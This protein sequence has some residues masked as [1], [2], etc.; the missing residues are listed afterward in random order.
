MGSG[1]CL[2]V[3]ALG[4]LAG[5]GETIE[6]TRRVVEVR[7]WLASHQASRRRSASDWY[8]AVFAYVLVGAMLAAAVSDMTV[9]L[10]A[11]PAGADSVMSV[12][13]ALVLASS[14][15][16]AWLLGPLTVPAP[17][18]WWLYSSPL[19]R[20][21]LLH[22]P[23]LKVVAAAVLAGL[24]VVGLVWL[25][26]APTAGWVTAAATAPL[27]GTMLA[28]VV[29][30]HRGSPRVWRAAP[31]FLIAVVVC[32]LGWVVAAV[33]AVS[34]MVLGVSAWR[35]LG[36]M[37]RFALEAAGRSA[38]SI[39]GGAI[40]V[41]STLLLDLVQGRLSRPARHRLRGAGRGWR[42]LAWVD[43]QRVASR[44]TW[45]MLGGA[46]AADAA[47]VAIAQVAPAL[48]VWAALVLMPILAAGMGT[49]R[50]LA[51]SVGLRRT[52]PAG[53]LFSLVSATGAVAVAAVNAVA[54][55]VMLT[56]PGAVMLWAVVTALVLNCAA[57]LGAW[58]M[59]TTASSDFSTGL[60]V[61]EA[62]V[63]PAGAML[64]MMRG[65][66]LLVTVLFVW[67]LLT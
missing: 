66:D 57:L 26:W 39:R 35:G 18:L 8:V 21:E 37:S 6:A 5:M 64:T 28:L 1:G 43:V 15:M 48:T 10:A 25:L 63:L 22:R 65:W 62:G 13:V 36:G 14:G 30:Q 52:L 58:R 19:D 53:R 24:V 41:D 38:S 42:A 47:C 11:L 49:R 55:A 40:S 3:L 51:F 56:I 12:L 2:P 61:T 46:L 29:Q 4:I 9:P 27:M 34:V 23:F 54:L 20:A 16:I 31:V 60:V 17:Q 50:R 67:Q 44:D 33:L 45:L 59:A 32:R 7:Q